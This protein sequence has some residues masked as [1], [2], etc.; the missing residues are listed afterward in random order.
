M[1]EISASDLSLINGDVHQYLFASMMHDQQKG[2]SAMQSA[3]VLAHPNIAFINYW[4]NRD[5][6][7][8]LPFN[9]SISM[10]LDGLF[11]HTTVNFSASYLPRA[12]S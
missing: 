12:C 11:T 5:N 3:A 10:N 8:R 9:G 7:L 2:D 1:P 4:G 6:A